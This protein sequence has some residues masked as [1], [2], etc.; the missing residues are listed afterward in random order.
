MDKDAQDNNWKTS[1]IHKPHAKEFF[2]ES[3]GTDE[4]KPLRIFPRPENKKLKELVEFSFFL[5]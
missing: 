3:L 5:S 1:Y 2:A 4:E